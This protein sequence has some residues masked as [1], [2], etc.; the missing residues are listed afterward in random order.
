MK[1]ITSSLIGKSV[2]LTLS[3]PWELGESV[4]WKP[5]FGTVIAEGIRPESSFGKAGEAILVQLSNPFVFN[6]IRYEYLQGSPRHEGKYLADLS[7]AKRELFCSFV[8]VSITQ[9][10]A[11]KRFDLSW[12]R[13]GGS[14]IGNLV[15]S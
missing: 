7:L 12:W 5:L 4:E 3:D 2:I 6:D 9:V 15:S 11:G 13:G 14:L 8:R 1:K 10:E